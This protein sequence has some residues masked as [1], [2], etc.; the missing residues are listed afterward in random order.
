MVGLLNIPGM[1]SRF[2]SGRASTLKR[3]PMSCAAATS[4]ELN[5][6]PGVA[7]EV[8]KGVNDVVEDA[9]KGVNGELTRV[10]LKAERAENS[11]DVESVFTDDTLAFG[12]GLGADKSPVFCKTQAVDI[13]P[14]P[15]V[16]ELLVECC[17]LS[18]AISAA[19]TIRPGRDSTDGLINEVDSPFLFM[20]TDDTVDVTRA[21][22][23]RSESKV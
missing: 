8:V 11:E 1:G 22:L 3:D 10:D 17:L 4:S 12:I 21:W 9:V 16:H 19:E 15:A 14:I 5:E 6:V 23:V 20:V 7:K 13:S 2:H 18:F